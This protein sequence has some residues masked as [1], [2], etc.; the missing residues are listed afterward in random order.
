MSPAR[1]RDAQEAGGRAAA[2]YSTYILREPNACHFALA[3]VKRIA[4]LFV[5][6]LSVTPVPRGSKEAC[7]KVQ[8]FSRLRQK[9]G[10]ALLDFDAFVDSSLHTS[11]E[12]SRESYASFAAFMDGFHI[13]GWRRVLNE[14]ASETLN[15]GLGLG[16]VALTLAGLAFQETSDDWLKKTDLAVTFLDRYG[17]EVGRRGIRHDDKVSFDELPPNLI[18]AVVAT[19][20]RRFFE[21]FGDRRDRHAARADRQCAG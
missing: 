13:A 6:Q 4:T 1:A 12:L 9:I 15:I 21:H 17:Q 2:S 3:I 5:R 19:E 10:R 18:H 11:M 20:D 7:L 8:R 16:V 14:F